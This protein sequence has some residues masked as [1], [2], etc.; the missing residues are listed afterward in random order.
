[1]NMH[2]LARYTHHSQD[3]RI[4]AELLQ[5]YDAQYMFQDLQK[6]IE[7]KAVLDAQ[8]ERF[9]SFLAHKEVITPG[10]KYADA[11]ILVSEIETFEQFL[12]NGRAEQAYADFQNLL[13]S[14][15][16]RSFLELLQERLPMFGAYALVKHE[17]NGYNGMELDREVESYFIESL[18]EDKR[19]RNLSG[20]PEKRRKILQKFA[21]FIVNPLDDY[22]PAGSF[23]ANRQIS[24]I[25]ESSRSSY[26]K[27]NPVDIVVCG[28]DYLVD[29]FITAV[30]VSISEGNLKDV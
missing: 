24:K 9:L 26:H 4:P 2:L 11:K 19:F 5:T 1:M 3:G 30:N 6:D 15:A 13:V 17:Q 27:F 7:N 25:I 12:P 21:N 20:L 23:C 28:E 16:E 22:C 10:R 18:Q 29:E 8:T 14:D